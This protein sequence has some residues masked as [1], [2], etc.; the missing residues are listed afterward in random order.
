M[1]FITVIGIISFIIFVISCVTI[2]HNTNSYEPSKRIVYIIVRY[3]H[4]VH[5]NCWNLH[6][7][8]KRNKYKK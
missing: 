8:L 1:T 5:Y 7:R 6:D 2:Y 3:N 4:N